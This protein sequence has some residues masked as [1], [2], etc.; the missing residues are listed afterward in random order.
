MHDSLTDTRACT[1]L[2]SPVENQLLPLQRLQQAPRDCL[3]F[4]LLLVG[5]LGLGLSQDIEDRELL[6][7]EAFAKVAFFLL[8]KFAHES[9][10]FIEQLLHIQAASI[11]AID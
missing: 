8:I 10:E 5:Q 11:V 4:D 1:I 7:A 2:A 9:H 6:L 3:D